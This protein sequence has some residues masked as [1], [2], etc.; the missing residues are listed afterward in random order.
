MSWATKPCSVTVCWIDVLCQR[1][2]VVA[3][4]AESLPVALIPEQFLVATVRD[5]VIHHRC[6]DVL[7]M[8]GTLRTQ[9]MGFK[10][11]LPGFL[12]AAVVSTLCCWASNFRVERQVLLTVELAGFDQFWA[13]GV[14]ARCLWSVRHRSVLPR[15]TSLTE[16]T[17][18]TD[19]VVVYI[20]QPQSL[21][22]S[23]RREVVTVMD[24]GFD[25]IQRLM[26][27]SEAI[28]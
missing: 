8:P 13:S 9:R 20:Q 1:F 10:I 5:D 2:P 22:D 18:G 28:H 12:P 11:R 6:P 25:E 19:L 4:F 16:V 7:A 21:N 15:K 23:L 27:R 3:L 26:L 17:V 24:V 14:P